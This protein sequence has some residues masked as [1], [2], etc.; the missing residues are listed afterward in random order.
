MKL[1][2]DIGIWTQYIWHN[3]MWSTTGLTTFMKIISSKQI[4][5]IIFFPRADLANTA[6][7][8]DVRDRASAFWNALEPISDE[9]NKIEAVQLAGAWVQV[10]EMWWIVAFLQHP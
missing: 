7:K 6:K 10:T 5:W 9:F 8:K 4:F 1:F 3:R 2:K